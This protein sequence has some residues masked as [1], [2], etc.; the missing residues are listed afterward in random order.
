[1][2]LESRLTRPQIKYDNWGI[3]DLTTFKLQWIGPDRNIDCARKV[4]AG[5]CQVRADPP[6][7]LAL[8]TDIG[9]SS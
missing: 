7:T 3:A 5:G 1:M 9:V 8:R 4:W 6:Q 2:P